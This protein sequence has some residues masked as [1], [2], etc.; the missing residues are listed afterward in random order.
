M[1]DTAVD[2]VALE[3][4]DG[5]IV[6]HIDNV[7]VHT[8][9]GH[10][11]K[12]HA[13]TWTIEKYQQEFPDAPLLSDMAKKAIA[14]RAAQKAKE[15]AQAA[16][17]ASAASAGGAIAPAP[18]NTKFAAFHEVFG[19]GTAKAAMSASGGPIQISVL[20]GHCAEGQAYMPKFDGGY[21]FNIDLTKKVIIGFE[22]NK[23]TYLWGFHGTGKTTVLQQCSV[24]TGRPMIRV[25]HTLNMQESEV[26]GNWIVKDGAT[27]FQL[28]PLPMAMLYGWTYCADEYDR[29]MPGVLALYQPVLEG[30]S[31]LIKDAPPEFRK[32]EAHPQFRFVATG[33]TNG[34]GDETGLYQGTIIQD[35]ANYSRFAITEEVPYM[36]AKIEQSILVSK[37]A[38]PQ[39][40]A[41]KIVKFANEIRKM[42][43]DGKISMTVSP[44][45]LIS[46]CELGIAYGGN[47]VLGLELAFANR[48][49]RVD[50]R[51]VQ[52]YMQR[53]FA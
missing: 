3:A 43:A 37:T 35:A 21:V 19:L 41:A 6:C 4:T 20:E 25:Q 29:G 42:F 10:I 15:T 31:L 38:V 34:C 2:T 47:Y 7:R 8:I 48:L 18:I 53:L 39:G 16:A 45:E 9:Q 49:S 27:L 52:E 5:K 24:R 32:I 13:D 40:D 12:N 14:D 33:N 46:A 23:P 51:T 11:N 44:R 22:L 50:K 28:G 26:I 30:Q 36:E 17:V 1:T